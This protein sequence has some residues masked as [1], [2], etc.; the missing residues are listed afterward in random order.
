MFSLYYCHKVPAIQFVYYVEEV[1]H[2]NI[3]YIVMKQ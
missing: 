2:E 1:E 3:R